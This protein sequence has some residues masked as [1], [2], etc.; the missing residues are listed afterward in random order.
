MARKSKQDPFQS[1]P[2]V[3]DGEDVFIVFLSPAI[4]EIQ[5]QG[6]PVSSIDVNED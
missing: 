6:F 1:R 3:A 5:I 4:K 2:P